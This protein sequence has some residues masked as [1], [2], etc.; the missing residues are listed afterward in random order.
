MFELLTFSC[1]MVIG[2]VAS[3]TDFRE[4]KIYNSLT[5]PSIILGFIIWTVYS[6]VDGFIAS[7]LGFAIA[8]GIYLIIFFLGGFG[9]GDVKFAAAIGAI[10]GYPMVINWVVISAIVGGLFALA[11]LI[12]YRLKKTNRFQMKE[13]VFI[14]YGPPMALAVVFT[15]GY[16]YLGIAGFQ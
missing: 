12:R 6:G 1:L 11:L 7:V 5:Y 10:M 3:I 8:F 4:R 15:Y 2:T 16:N 13:S 9:A 14:P